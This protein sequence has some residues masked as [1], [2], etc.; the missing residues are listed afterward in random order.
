MTSDL[1]EAEYMTAACHGVR[2]V[3]RRGTGLYKIASTWH[4]VTQA[5]QSAQQAN[6]VFAKQKAG[7]LKLAFNIRT[8]SCP[9]SPADLCAFAC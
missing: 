8:V 2:S 5:M 7:L 9:V 6:G 1:V 3:G 4:C